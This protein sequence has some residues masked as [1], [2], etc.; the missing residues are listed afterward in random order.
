MKK[1]QIFIFSIIL[2]ASCATTQEQVTKTGRFTVY[3]YGQS[4]VITRQWETS[5]FTETISGI[6]FE[7]GG[8]TWTL[9]GSYQI[10]EVK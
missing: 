1:I 3:E 6:T 5:S 2:L 8:T 10:D 7:S 9:T 4:G